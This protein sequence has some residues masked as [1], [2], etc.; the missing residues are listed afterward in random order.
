MT[1]HTR[2][3]HKESRLEKSSSVDNYSRPGSEVGVARTKVNGGG[4]GGGGATRRGVS[5][6]PRTARREFFNSYATISA[7]GK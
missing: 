5:L 3:P 1:I 4:G 6:S 7:G 2:S